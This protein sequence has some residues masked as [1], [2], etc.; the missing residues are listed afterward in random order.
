[1][2]KKNTSDD[3][4]AETNPVQTDEDKMYERALQEQRDNR[5][6]NEYALSHALSFH[7]NNGGMMN[8]HQLL[9]IANQFLNFLKGE[10]K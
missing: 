7:K 10:P 9:D 5:W 8:P 6:V 4:V 2:T 3:P 1:M